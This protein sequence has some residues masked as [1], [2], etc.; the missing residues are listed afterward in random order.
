MTNTNPLW[1]TLL[2]AAVLLIGVLFALP[3]LFGSDPAVQ[4]SARS[5][6]LTANDVA[7]FNKIL[8]DSGFTDA[9]IREDD[10]RYLALFTSED[11]QL[12]A[13]DAL[14]A[15]L[16]PNSYITALN[17]VDASPAWLRNIAQPM[18]LG[19]D[20]RGGV[21]FL[22]EVDM[23]AAI[24]SAEERF[25][26]AWKR[27]VREAKIRGTSIQHSKGELSARF[28]D[29]AERDRM[30]DVFREEAQDLEF[31]T[32]EEGEF[33]YITAKLSEIAIQEEQRSAL[34]QN[35]VTLRN[36]INEL[37]VS[38]P[39]IQQQGLERI[40]VQLP[41]VQDTAR[42]K[43]ILGA[44]ATLEYRLVSTRSDAR[45]YKRR[46]DGSTIMLDRDI[47]VTGDQIKGAS[48]GI[49][50]Q[51]G[52]AAV[53]V[54][55]DNAGARRMQE[56]TQENVGNLMAVVYIENRIDNI[57]VNGETVK[58][59]TK[60]E[61]VINAATIRDV[62]SHRF[63]TTGLGAQEAA[64]LA[65]LLRAGALKAP[66][67]IVEERTVGPSLGKDNIRQGFMSAV[68]GLAIVVVFMAVYYRVFGIIAGL[69]LVTNVVLIIAVLGALTA[70]LTLPG[71]AGIVLTVGMAVDA[72]VLI[73][74]RIREELKSGTAVQTAISA[75]YDKAFSTIADANVTT[76]IAA[77]V[78]FSLG[79]GPIKGFAVTLCI[80][81]LTSM[82]TAIFGT[83]VIVNTLYG[84]RRLNT[85]PI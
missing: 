15:E 21:H 78:L 74:E 57:Q 14:A 76:L 48:S 11:E 84:G 43:E 68:V 55:L 33:A 10:G 1:K 79:T 4:I 41:G 63:Q 80:G 31:Q 34:Q 39:V 40:V 13:R 6:E 29:V 30:L 22:M 50:Q 67:Q 16:D 2:L 17:L 28:K 26:P 42:A 58:K 69:A 75:G 54:N 44:T 81:I 47:I 77:V 27:E 5:A 12:R 82:F 73:F 62:L 46:E 70:T 72:N 45:P 53:F 71:I 23:E 9:E 66:V 3:N 35:I 36:R 32:S 59:V 51:T 52:T 7:K 19:L 38:E 64:D 61:E 37:G 60:V 83:R 18:F 65:L 8:A 24:A 25:I 20:L 49:D 85:L 56:V